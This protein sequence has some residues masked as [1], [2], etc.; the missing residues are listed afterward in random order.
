[1]IHGAI[2][3]DIVGSRFETMNYKHKDF[4]L[5]A[6]N[7]CFTD[8]SVMTVAVAEA[9]LTDGDFVSAMQK[10]GRKYPRAGYGGKFYAW[11]FSDDPRPYGSWG[12]GSAMRVSPCGLAAKSMEEAMELAEQSARVSHN[13]PEGIKGAKA[14]AAAVYMAKTGCGRE[15]IR[16]YIEKNFYHLD[17]T[18]EEIRPGYGFDVSCQGSVPQAILCFLESEDFEDAIRNAISLGG[19][20][21]T[22]AAMAGSIAWVYYSRDNG[23]TPR[24]EEIWAEAVE[25]LPD[26]MMR[27]VRRVSEIVD[28]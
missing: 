26:D 27:I 9:L 24:M 16:A 3:G 12:N 22:I 23:P 10:W 2:I 15:E 8:D 14:V 25:Y 7:N 18:L 1:M 13:H 17:T 11:I 21:D 28:R 20:S 4:H 5:F 6:Y 19:D